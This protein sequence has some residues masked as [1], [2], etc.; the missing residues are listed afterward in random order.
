MQKTRREAKM[1]VT[2]AVSA[3]NHVNVRAGIQRQTEN[4]AAEQLKQIPGFS[5]ASKCNRRD[6]KGANHEGRLG[7]NG[8]GPQGK[9]GQGRRGLEETQ[10][11][12]YNFG[13]CG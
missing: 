3:G 6:A 4:G 9:N 8:L 12:E 5:V 2:L 1:A 10:D 11:E 13:E 7:T